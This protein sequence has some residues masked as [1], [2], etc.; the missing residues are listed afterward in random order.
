MNILSNVEIVRLAC[1]LLGVSSNVSNLDTPSNAT[2]RKAARMY[3]QAVRTELGKR[4]WTFATAR[5]TLEPDLS[6]GGHRIAGYTRCAIP[7]TALRFWKADG[8]DWIRE[9]GFLHSRYATGLAVRF[10]AR[11]PEDE[12]DPLFTDLLIVAV[13]MNLAEWATSK[14]T[15]S[16]RLATEY[17]RR[18]REAARANAFEIGPENLNGAPTTWQSE[19]WA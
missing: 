15:L 13:A 19:R 3:E 10:T 6:A 7:A 11:V 5:E 4:R 17:E 14:S 8:D 2:E 18:R 9:G 16:D 12:F 1:D